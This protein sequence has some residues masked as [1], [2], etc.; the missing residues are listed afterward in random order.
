MPDPISWSLVWPYY[1]A[2]LVGG[3][4]L[5]S[6]P[7]GLVLTRLAG[8][9]DI[10]KIGSGNIGATNV[11]RTGSKPLAALTVLGDGLK[12]TLAVLVAAGYGG[13]DLAVTAGLG[14]FIGHC[15]PLWLKFR[16]G[17]GVATF[18]GIALGLVWWVMLIAAGI[19][20]A[21]AAIS[22]FSSLSALIASAAA[23]VLFIAFGERQYGELFVVLAAILW[24]RHRDNIKRLLTG[25]EGRIGQ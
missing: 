13:P 1:L 11:L 17:K 25:S 3:Y 2:A 20:L 24:I 15:F 5:G 16:G 22:R 12:G 21:V 10:R 8:K 9:G 23:P 18:L 6:V 14:V 7:F 19:W 4:L